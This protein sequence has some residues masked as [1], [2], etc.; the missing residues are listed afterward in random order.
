M[1]FLC[2]REQNSFH[3]KALVLKYESLFELHNGVVFLEL[4][5]WVFFWPILFLWSI[6]TEITLLTTIEKVKVILTFDLTQV[7]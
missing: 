3:P 2:N 4:L 1:I 5:I 7:F 6:V